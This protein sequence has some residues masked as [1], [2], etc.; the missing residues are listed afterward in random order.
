MSAR[1]RRKKRIAVRQAARAAWIDSTFQHFLRLLLI[2]SL[3]KTVIP[4]KMTD[5]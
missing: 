1:H 2:Q 4:A 5:G 3:R